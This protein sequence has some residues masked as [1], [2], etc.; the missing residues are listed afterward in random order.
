MP[1]QVKEP[2]LCTPAHFVMFILTFGPH[3]VEVC[4]AHSFHFAEENIQAHL[5]A[6]AMGVHSV[7]KI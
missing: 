3:L 2:L 1:S 5:A 6:I 4:R 7:I